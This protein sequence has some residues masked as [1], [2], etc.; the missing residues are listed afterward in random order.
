V[1]F[2][3]DAG[4]IEAVGTCI[5]E[6]YQL[7]NRLLDSGRINEKTFRSC[8]KNYVLSGLV[9]GRPGC[10]NPIDRFSPVVKLGKIADLPV[11]D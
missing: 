8:Y 5:G 6:S 4:S 10:A 11:L 2:F 9:N 1:F 3:A 7:I